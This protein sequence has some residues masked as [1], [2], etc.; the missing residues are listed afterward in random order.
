MHIANVI[1]T[2]RSLLATAEFNYGSGRKGTA[3]EY[4]ARLGIFLAVELPG[5]TTE[6]AYLCAEAAISETLAKEKEAQ[7]LLDENSEVPEQA[8]EPVHQSA[9]CVPDKSRDKPDEIPEPIK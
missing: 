4:L 8:S 6:A 1:V 9:H 7:A 5:I 3:S 2:C